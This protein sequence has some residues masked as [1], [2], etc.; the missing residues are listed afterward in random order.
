MKTTAP[1]ARRSG[2]RKAAPALSRSGAASS[3]PVVTGKAVPRAALPATG[4]W[5]AFR[6]SIIDE[7]PAKRI[8]RI[9][10]GTN[11][12]S[13]VGAATT[14][15]V[16]RETIFGLV[17]LPTSTANRKI[18]RGELL[19][20]AATER[21][22]RIALIGRDA[23]ETFGDPEIARAWLTSGNTALGGAT[24]LSLL[25]TDIGTREVS[26]VLVAINYGGAA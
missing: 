24:P 14:L 15:G 22:A 12:H 8:Q 11:A 19:E 26:K 21:L 6:K 17:G 1:A 4:N 20:T 9:R 7:A 25:D 3:K 10:S 16:S 2:A 13:L 5:E 18:A 23:E